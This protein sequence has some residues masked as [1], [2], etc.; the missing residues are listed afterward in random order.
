MIE[1]WKAD[2]DWIEAF[3]VAQNERSRV[4]RGVLD[5]DDSPCNIEDVVEVVAK[6]DGCNDDESWLM[7][8]RL[9][10]KRYFFLSAWCDYTGWG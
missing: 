1:K 9:K 10:D 7:A 8:G 3:K 4:G 5:V 6:R 2:Y